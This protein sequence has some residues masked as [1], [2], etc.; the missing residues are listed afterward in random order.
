MLLST[1]GV[2]SR[3]MG[4]GNSREGG[5]MCRIGSRRTDGRGFAPPPTA[6]PTVPSTAAST[7]PLLYEAWGVAG[8]AGRVGGWRSNGWS[9]RVVKHLEGHVGGGCR[10]TW[11]G[12]QFPD[13]TQRCAARAEPAIHLR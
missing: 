8:A 4:R 12:S 13:V 1:E 10:K 9:N 5:G 2:Y 7:P 6:L 3:D 11:E